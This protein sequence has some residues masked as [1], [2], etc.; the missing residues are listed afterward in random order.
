METVDGSIVP[1]YQF[2]HG[3]NFSVH[4]SDRVGAELPTASAVT[5][6]DGHV[7]VRVWRTE[8]WETIPRGMRELSRCL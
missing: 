3:G 5:E 6:R 4:S 1:G 7:D 2:R 8:S